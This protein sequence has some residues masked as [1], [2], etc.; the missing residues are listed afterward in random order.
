MRPNNID[1]NGDTGFLK[2]KRKPSDPLTPSGRTPVAN[3]DMQAKQTTP[4]ATQAMLKVE[5]RYRKEGKSVQ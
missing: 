5:N 1:K 3:K 2:K 4:W